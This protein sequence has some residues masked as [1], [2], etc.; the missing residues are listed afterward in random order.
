MVPADFITFFS[1]SA[2]ASATLIGLLF[3]AISFQPARI[4]GSGARGSPDQGG[5]RL[6][7]SG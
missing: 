5:Q 1:V 6:H 3:I 4:F 7:R 2:G